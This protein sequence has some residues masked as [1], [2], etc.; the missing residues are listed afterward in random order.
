MDTVKCERCDEDRQ[1]GK[2]FCKIC[3]GVVLDELRASGTLAPRA[4]HGNT[5]ETKHGRDG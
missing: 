1:A 4:Y 3:E 2:R 5:R